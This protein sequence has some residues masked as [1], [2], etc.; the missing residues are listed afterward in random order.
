[1]FSANRN[2]DFLG[3]LGCI[4]LVA[5]LLIFAA[6]CFVLPAFGGYE[7]CGDDE[8]CDDPITCPGR[9]CKGMYS[10]CYCVDQMGNGCLCLK[11]I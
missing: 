6:D 3:S 8:V 5:T 4:L 7:S 11:E 2:L 1:M 10:G 9:N